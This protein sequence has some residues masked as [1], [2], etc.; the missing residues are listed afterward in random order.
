[1]N[2]VLVA[3]AVRAGLFLAGCATVGTRQA[4]GPRVI[5]TFDERGMTG[6][7][8]SLVRDGSSIRG[9]AYGRPVSLEWDGAG[10]KGSYWNLPVKLAVTPAGEATQVDGELFGAL[11]AF[12]YTSRRLEGLL[13]G[14]AF[15]FESTGGSQFE[16]RRAC[17]G[18]KVE[19]LSIAVPQQL[20]QRSEAE[21][22]AWLALLLTDE[23]VEAPFVRAQVLVGGEK[24]Q[25]APSGCKRQQ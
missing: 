2:K 22:A 5:A 14:C 10:V 17:V 15:L 19:G 18:K 3:T 1:M 20:A 7:N 9:N 11:A 13:G 25:Q 6:Q 21:R 8:V 24:I 16:G 12:E 4:T 23:T